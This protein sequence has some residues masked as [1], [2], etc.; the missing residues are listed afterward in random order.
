M[1]EVR[2]QDPDISRG[3]SALSTVT[4]G[5]HESPLPEDYTA[6]DPACAPSFLLRV[7]ALLHLSLYLEKNLK[8]PTV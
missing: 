6:R 7:L 2:A 4:H 5:H 8:N 1:E 3:D